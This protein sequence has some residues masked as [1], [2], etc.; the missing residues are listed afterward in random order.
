MLQ[1]RLMQIQ[2]LQSR[3]LADLM[4]LCIEL[5][6]GNQ[7]VLTQATCTLQLLDGL[8]LQ[9]RRRANIADV[10]MERCMKS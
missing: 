1:G 2:A 7:R 9:S 5:C 6:T 3:R 4:E 10:C 8:A